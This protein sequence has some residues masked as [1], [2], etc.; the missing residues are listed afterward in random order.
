ME[1]LFGNITP[2]VY[3]QHYAVHLPEG[4]E[5]KA[6]IARYDGTTDEVTEIKPEVFYLVA[7]PTAHPIYEHF[8]VQTF[9]ELLRHSKSHHTLQQLGELMYQSHS[10]Y[11]ACG[12]G[13]DGTDRL[14]ELA[15][16]FGSEKGIYGGKITGG[17]RGGTVAILGKADAYHSVEMIAEKYAEETGIMPYI[18][19][20]SSMGAHD[21]GH[22]ILG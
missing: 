11:S 19:S 4:I 7:K 9:T 14:V 15:R 10:S 2:S 20:G 3:E 18:F 6:F 16:E 17:G 22:I 21:F 12:L 8:R 13:A 1:R 5:G